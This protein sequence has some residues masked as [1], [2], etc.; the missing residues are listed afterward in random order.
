MDM[1]SVD[2]NDELTPPDMATQSLQQAQATALLNLLTINKSSQDTHSAPV[3]R[4]ASPAPGGKDSAPP[5]WKV[6]ILDETS[7]DI[8]ATILRVQDLRDVGVTL[9]VSV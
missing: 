3:S 8:L 1:I 9:H 5:V 6:L 7:K 4:T 2:S